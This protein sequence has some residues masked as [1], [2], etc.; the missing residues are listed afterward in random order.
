MR[1]VADVLLHATPCTEDWSFVKVSTGDSFLHL[2]C[3]TERRLASICSAGALLEGV[4][5]PRGVKSMV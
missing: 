3:S 2:L 5:V 1:L 4:E